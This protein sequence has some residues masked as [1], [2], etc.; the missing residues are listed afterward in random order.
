MKDKD[1][2]DV[3]NANGKN[4]TTRKRKPQLVQQLQGQPQCLRTL[5]FIFGRANVSTQL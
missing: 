3:T 2:K 4:N 1:G 5:K